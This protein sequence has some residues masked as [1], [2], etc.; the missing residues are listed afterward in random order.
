MHGDVAAAI[1]R[2][3]K[4]GGLFVLIDSLQHGDRPEFDALLES[5]PFAFHEPYYADY[6]RQDLTTLFVEAGFEQESVELAY[7][8]R[9]MTFRRRGG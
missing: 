1:A 5:F 2:L 6:L 4:P 3:V 8:S 7:L 9:V